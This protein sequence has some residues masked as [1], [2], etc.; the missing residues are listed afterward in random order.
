MFFD[1]SSILPIAYINIYLGSR[2]V[3]VHKHQVTR[4]NSTNILYDRLRIGGEDLG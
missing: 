2:G 4:V 1:G 3:H